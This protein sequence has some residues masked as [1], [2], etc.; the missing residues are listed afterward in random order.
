[1]SETT[2]SHCGGTDTCYQM[3][4]AGT[5]YYCETCEEVFP[6]EPG[7]APRRVQMIADGKLAELRWE[8]REELLT[9]ED[10]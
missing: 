8:M 3:F 10:R 5:E 4:S 9:Q 2:C 1:M 6:Y 7:T